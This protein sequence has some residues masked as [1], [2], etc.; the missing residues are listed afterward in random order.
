MRRGKKMNLYFTNGHLVLYEREINLYRLGLPICIGFTF[1]YIRDTLF[2]YKI[3]DFA[4][5]Q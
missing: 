5:S 4:I 1:M 2:L 3:V